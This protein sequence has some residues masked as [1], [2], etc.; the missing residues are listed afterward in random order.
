MPLFATIILAALAESIVSFSG[1]AL[2]IFKEEKVRRAAHFIVSFAVGALLGVS[3]L[4]L[5]PEAIEMSSVGAILPWTLVGIILFF[6]L[7]KFL[8]WYHCHDGNCPAHPYTYL[9]LWGDFIHNFIDGIILALAFLADIKLG[10]LTTIAVIVHELPQEIGDFGTLVHGGFSRRRAL[11]YNFLVSLSTIVGASLTY[12]FGGF[13]EPFLP[14]ALA[15]VAGN[16]IYI[17]SSDLIPE[18]HE[19]TKF[20]HSVAQ[21]FFIAAGV[22]LVIAPEFLLF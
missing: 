5:L 20:S 1:A 11:K 4:E 10:V 3:F 16:F 12:A 8:F 15:L 18:L 19:S 9:I 6:I 2:V 21:I 7:E 22:L 14:F 17:A 13:L